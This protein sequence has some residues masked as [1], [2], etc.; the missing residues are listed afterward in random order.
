MYLR[1]NPGSKT[2]AEVVKRVA[3][4]SR[5]FSQLEKKQQSEEEGDDEIAQKSD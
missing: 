1:N 4:Q 3:V 2:Y 5:V